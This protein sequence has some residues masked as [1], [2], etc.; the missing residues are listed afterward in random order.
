MSHSRTPAASP[1]SHSALNPDRHF[2]LEHIG[3]HKNLQVLVYR[4]D[5]RYHTVACPF[6]SRPHPASAV[7]NA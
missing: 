1:P 7:P 2:L 3:S 5:K 6:C 4:L